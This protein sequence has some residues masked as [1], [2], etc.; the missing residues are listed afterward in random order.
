MAKARKKEKDTGKIKKKRWFAIHANE[1]FS[2]MV[3]GETSGYEISTCMGKSLKINLMVL[4]NEVKNQSVNIRFKVT[5]IQDDK[6][7]ADHIAYILSPA[8]IKRVVRRR[9]TRLDEAHVFT[10]ADGVKVSIKPLLITRTLC[11]RST[12]ASLHK[13]SQK[14]MSSAVSQL[15]L[16]EL[17]SDIIT[18]KLQRDMRKGLNK[19]FPVKTYEIKKLERL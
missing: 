8:Y 12:I 18:Q 7:Y 10:T 2:D 9:H 16:D 11:E 13:H 15:K 19:I 6:V 17:F 4:T 3:L 1:L 5:R 14:M